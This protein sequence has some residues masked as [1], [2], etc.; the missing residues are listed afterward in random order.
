MT[1]EEL[2]DLAEPIVQ[3][4][5]DLED[6]KYQELQKTNENLGV[7]IELLTE[8]QTENATF[9]DE[10]ITYISTEEI[11]EIETQELQSLE[12]EFVEDSINYDKS[13]NEYL[14]TIAINTEPLEV[15]EE[16]QRLDLLSK[17]AILVILVMLTIF[18]VFYFVRYVFNM[19][20]KH[21]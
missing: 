11:E 20:T 9:R 10:V 7:L 16:I 18:G 4:L 14:A 2:F 1:N 6:L 21:F 5:S 8:I 13:N 17:S 15:D 12:V 19:F 3:N